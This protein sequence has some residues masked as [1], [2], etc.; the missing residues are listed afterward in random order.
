[1]RVTKLVVNYLLLYKVLW[2]V[3]VFLLG[4]GAVV[5]EYAL[6][7]YRSTAPS[8]FYSN[9]AVMVSWSSWVSASCAAL[10]FY[11]FGMSAWLIPILLGYVAFVIYKKYRLQDEKLRLS[12]FVV[13]FCALSLFAA[14]GTGCQWHDLLLFG[15]LIGNFLLFFVRTFDVFALRIV[16]LFTI[17]LSFVLITRLFFVKYVFRFAHATV[18]FARK[19]NIFDRACVVIFRILHELVHMISWCFSLPSRYLHPA[20]IRE[21]ESEDVFLDEVVNDVFWEAYKLAA[22]HVSPSY[23]ATNTPAEIKQEYHVSLH[24]IFGR[25]TG[26]RKNTDI[27]SS[28][29]TR[30]ASILEEKLAHFGVHGHV[31]E[32]KSGPVVTCFEY[33][34]AVDTKLSKITALADDLLLALQALSLRIIAPI[35]G[36]NV[37][38]FE[39]ARVHRQTVSFAQLLHDG[40]K[41]LDDKLPLLLG[42]DVV[43]KPVSVDLVRLPHI[44]MAGSTGSGKSVALH[45]MI[46]SLLINKSPHD[47]KLILIDP[48]RL[49]LRAYDGIG[50][51]LF[52]V[53]TEVA[54]TLQ[55]LNWLMRA[56]HERYEKMAEYDARNIAQYHA[57]V[58]EQERAQMPYIVVVI[59]ELA[60]LMLAAGNQLEVLIVRIAQMARAAGIHLIVATQR[61][62]VDVIT[63]LI[64]VNFVSRIALRVTSAIDSRVILDEDGAQRL[65]GAGDMLM[66][67][68]NGMLKRIHG[69]FCTN[70]EIARVVSHIKKH[71]PLDKPSFVHLEQ[72][73]LSDESDPLYAEVLSFL[74]EIDE[75]SISLLQ[76]RF[77]IGFNRSARIIDHLEADGRIVNVGS[78]KTRKVVRS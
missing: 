28:D 46:L 33:E 48:K 10:A 25:L 63:G 23:L 1:M 65:V 8:V 14:L 76:R 45:S 12:M 75:V 42:A 22:A 44:L 41:H 16:L 13:L 6:L 77:R 73:V 20:L 66:R 61:P 59:D 39:V 43:G 69:A 50:H 24:D 64:K 35:P 74:Q 49:E 68:G 29:I 71:Y 4:A 58:G 52:P 18:I 57:C 32:V 17:C 31:R 2:L 26:E 70:E 53:I 27:V 55:V 38:G 9:S 67:D 56:M 34:P 72:T 60:D 51:L 30:D 3:S 15:G 11:I 37:V 78:G 47:L 36:T 5:F 62:S 40:D 54:Q 19:N 21:V 7:V